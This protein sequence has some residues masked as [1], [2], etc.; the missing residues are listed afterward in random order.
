MLQEW[1][2]SVVQRDKNEPSDP[3]V[4]KPYEAGHTNLKASLNRFN[5]VS[6][7]EYE[8]GDELQMEEYIFWDCKL[9][10]D[11]WTTVMDILSESRKKGIPKVSY[12]ALRARGKKICARRLLLHKQNSNI[13]LNNSIRYVRKEK[14]ANV[15]NINSI[16]SDLRDIYTSIY[17]SLQWNKMFVGLC[18]RGPDGH[19]LGLF[20]I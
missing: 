5:I 10:E 20:C 4:N 14:E 13:Y 11:Q 8:C 2:V 3:C 15:P 1:L 17:I 9:Y 7:V 19:C 18:Y 6:T 12:R 16:L